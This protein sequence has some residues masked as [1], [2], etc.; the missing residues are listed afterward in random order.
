MVGATFLDFV[1]AMFQDTSVDTSTS[2]QIGFI[3]GDGNQGYIDANPGV[4][5]SISQTV[6]GP[7]PDQTVLFNVSGSAGTNSVGTSIVQN[8]DGTI[9]SQGTTFSTGYG[10]T[11]LGPWQV[12]VPFSPSIPQDPY[13]GPYRLST[14]GGFIDINP[15]SCYCLP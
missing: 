9:S 13:S 7:T 2:V 15:D 6:E 10:V 5:V 4:G 3:E 1:N 8:P 11:L 12:Q 14:S